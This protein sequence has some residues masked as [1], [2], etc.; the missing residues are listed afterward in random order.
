MFHYCNLKYNVYFIII[1]TTLYYHFILLQ[2]VL[3]IDE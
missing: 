2:C 1:D 3:L